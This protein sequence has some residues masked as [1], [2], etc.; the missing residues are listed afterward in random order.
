VQAASIS[1]ASDILAAEAAARRGGHEAHQSASVRLREAEAAA[2]EQHARAVSERVRFQADAATAANAGAVL[3]LEHWLQG[4]AN[5]LGRSP[6][7]IID[8][9]IPRDQ[10]PFL[11]Y[12]A[13]PTGG[14]PATDAALPARKTP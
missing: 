13:S 9:R 12:R 6:L 1:A 10:L 5:T 7:V 11:D 14:T 8:H 2:A 3:E 4:L